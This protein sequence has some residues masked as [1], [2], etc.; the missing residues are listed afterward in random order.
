M[1]VSKLSKKLN[2][3]AASW[4]IDPF[5]PNLQLKNF[6]QSL[7]THPNLTQKAVDAAAALKDDAIIKKVPN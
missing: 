3:I 7:S 2:I 5:R 4:P 6:L 1:S